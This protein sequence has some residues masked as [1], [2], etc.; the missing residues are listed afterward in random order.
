ML[1][2]NN[3]QRRD[4]SDDVIAAWQQ[5]I[6]EGSR[7][8][9]VRERLANQGELFFPRFA[10]H[11][12]TLR[13]LPRRARRSLQK[14]WKH[15][16]AGVAL[17]L[18]LNGA[19]ALANEINVGVGG[20]TLVDAITAANTNTA[21]GN[22]PAGGGADTIILPAGS[23][24]TLT[25]VDPYN[26]FGPSGLPPILSN[27]TIQGNGSEITRAP[28]SP[29][30]RI[31]SA[32]S[33]FT[34]Q[35]TTISGGRAVGASISN[36][37]GGGIFNA[38][39][40]TLINST[41]TGNMAS[42]G[43][44]IHNLGDMTLINSTI[45]NNTATY[46]GG[47]VYNYDI[48]P[49]QAH[50]GLLTVINSTISDNS[51][52][53]GG[54]VVN[55]SGG[56]LTV[57]SSTISGNSGDV[58]GGVYNRIRSFQFQKPTTATLINSTVSD[59]PGGGVASIGETPPNLNANLTVINSTISGNSLP[60]GGVVNGGAMTLSRTLIS[61]NTGFSNLEVTN[62]GELNAD[63]FNLFGSNG[64]SG[65]NFAVTGTDIVPGA[66]VMVSDILAPLANNGGPTLTHALVTGSPAIDA[67]PDDAGCEDTDQRGVTR[68][69]GAACDIGSFE[70]GAGPPEPPEITCAG[71]APT[72]GCTVNDAPNQLCVG[73]EEKDSIVGTSGND[74]IIALGGKDRVEA[75]GGDDIV[76]GGDGKDQLF[77]NSGNDMLFGDAGADGLFGGSDD[78]I[79]DGGEGKN[80]LDGEDGNDECI[81]VLGKDTAMNCELGI[82][83][84]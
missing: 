43:G 78:D 9:W 61:G 10:E 41:V 83:E 67:S 50:E 59:N 4:R 8:Q 37:V 21:T 84:N 72:E 79:L 30:F 82:N 17:L 54:G 51:A 33:D 65:T 14:T 25:A 49:Y 2:P 57:I 29:D 55:N 12:D 69:Q 3:S 13:A 26:R 56:N 45:S 80:T 63:D 36:G 20:C 81:G 74:V 15:T 71:L 23:T 22:C 75:G 18:A 70:L 62:L 47:G 77:G 19:P 11:Y 64:N 53:Y 44:G 28:G 68:P 35:N 27:I 24:Q 46:Y 39:R 42:N 16:L 6:A 76:C 40:V 48:G 38:L 1:L 34:L 73:T 32:L 5:G 66:G 31:I 58:V 52:T 60:A 7:H